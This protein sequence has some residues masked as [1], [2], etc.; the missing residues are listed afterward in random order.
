MPELRLPKGWQVYAM[1]PATQRTVT[2]L[3][4]AL[5]P[6]ISW[7]ANVSL[8]EPRSLHVVQRQWPRLLVQLSNDDGGV[9]ERQV[10][11]Q[12]HEVAGYACQY[13]HKTSRCITLSR[14]GIGYFVPRYHG[15]MVY[16][17]TYNTVS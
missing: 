9:C 15:A 12:Q 11:V 2:G 17:Y 1:L 10:E 16:W 5:P 8:T 4:C 14:M 13:L 6:K 3:H 7:G